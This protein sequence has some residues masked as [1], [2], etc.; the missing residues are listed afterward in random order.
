[1]CRNKRIRGSSGR[2]RGGSIERGGLKGSNTGV[3]RDR[4]IRGS[5][6]IIRIFRRIK[7]VK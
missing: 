3:S 5:I 1:M 4:K 6:N 7:G 2:Y